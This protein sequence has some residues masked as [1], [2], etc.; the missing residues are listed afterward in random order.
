MFLL[1]RRRKERKEGRGGLKSRRRVCSPPPVRGASISAS[2]KRHRHLRPERGA[3]TSCPHVDAKDVSVVS[4]TAAVE[5]E[6]WWVSRRCAGPSAAFCDGVIRL[7]LALPPARSPPTTTLSL[8]ITSS[9]SLSNHQHTNSR[10]LSSPSLALLLRCPGRRGLATGRR[11][12]LSS[13]FPTPLLPTT[14]HLLSPRPSK[15]SPC[16]S[17]TVSLSTMNVSSVPV[18]LTM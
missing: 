3:T 7:R 10:Y 9:L 1:P 5:E 15:P 11:R 8:R 18:D 2:A 17:S 4:C 16:P 14:R 12:T 6:I 13:S